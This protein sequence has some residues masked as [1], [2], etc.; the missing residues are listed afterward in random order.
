MS[1]QRRWR[2]RHRCCTRPAFTARCSCSATGPGALGFGVPV[3]WSRPSRSKEVASLLLGED[4]GVWRRTAVTRPSHLAS[5]RVCCA[6]V[7]SVCSDPGLAAYALAPRRAD[8]IGP[9]NSGIC[10]PGPG[11]GPGPRRG[12]WIGRSGARIRLPR[13]TP[14]WKR[15]STPHLSMSA[16]RM[17]VTVR[18]LMPSRP[19]ALASV[20]PA[21]SS[22]TSLRWRSSR[23]MTVASLSSK[24]GR[25]GTD[26]CSR[27][28]VW[29]LLR[30]TGVGLVG[31]STG[32]PWS[33]WSDVVR[34]PDPCAGDG[35]L[36]CRVS[37]PRG[38][39][40]LRR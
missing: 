9:P 1:R 11:P 4:I 20:C 29:L 26:R 2:G 8:D 33:L 14:S 37:V 35:A 32:L 18:G 36:K 5:V 30:R 6:I 24:V 3:G 39:R 15:L 19:A 25:T 17:F 7:V 34:R 21:S 16:R 28:G 40:C 22:A 23:G 13:A 12:G 27:P 10:S 38:T 31:L